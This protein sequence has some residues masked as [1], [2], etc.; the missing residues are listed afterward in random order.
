M[1]GKERLKCLQGTV[2]EL[3]QAALQL[4]Q[5]LVVVALGPGQLG[6][7]N[8]EYGRVSVSSLHGVRKEC[9]GGGS[10]GV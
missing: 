3:L 5:G 1:R 6:P 8:A 2:T 9:L 10:T 4:E 7:L